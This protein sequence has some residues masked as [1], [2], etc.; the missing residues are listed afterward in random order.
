MNSKNA[1]RISDLLPLVRSEGG[2][3]CC[4]FKGV[5]ARP[6][7]KVPIKV[8]GGFCESLSL[9]NTRVG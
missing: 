3:I 9:S 7:H 8:K 6:D 2:R 5:S 1:F 4:N